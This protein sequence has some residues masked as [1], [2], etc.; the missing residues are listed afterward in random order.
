MN[1][2]EKAEDWAALPFSEKLGIIRSVRRDAG[3]T[4]Q[5]AADKAGISKAYLSMLERGLYSTVR[6]ETLGKIADA[7]GCFLRVEIID[8]RAGKYY[9]VY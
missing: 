6:I 2:A 9:W 4:L 1:F 8:A 5:E 3:L 7:C